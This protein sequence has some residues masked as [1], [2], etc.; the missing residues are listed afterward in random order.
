MLMFKLGYRSREMAMAFTNSK[1]QYSEAFEKELGD[2]R[3]GQTK[4]G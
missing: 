3:I 2:A 1:R 4:G